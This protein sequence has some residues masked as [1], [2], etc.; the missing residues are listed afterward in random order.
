MLRNKRPPAE[1]WA[2][3]AASLGLAVPAA[4]EQAL[5]QKCGLYRDADTY[6]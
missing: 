3:H 1:V 6:V 4:V 5:Q 2:E